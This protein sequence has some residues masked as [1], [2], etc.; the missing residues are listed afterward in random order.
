MLLNSKEHRQYAKALRRNAPNLPLKKRAQAHKYAGG[1]VGA[2]E[3][4]EKNP[5]KYA[6]KPP[7]PPKSPAPKASPSKDCISTTC[8]AGR[9]GSLQFSRLNS[10]SLPAGRRARSQPFARCSRQREADSGTAAQRRRRGPGHR[11]V[12][13]DRAGYQQAAEGRA[14]HLDLRSGLRLSY[15]AAIGANPATYRP[16][17]WRRHGA[18]FRGRCPVPPRLRREARRM[19]RTSA[20]A[21][22][23]FRRNISYQAFEHALHHAFEAGMAWVF[24]KCRRLTPSGA[25]LVIAVALLWLP[26]SFGIATALHATLIARAKSLPAWMQL[27]HAFATF[28]AKS[29]LLVLPV[30]PAAWPQAKEHPI[31]RGFSS[32]VVIARASIPADRTRRRRGG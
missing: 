28:I 21:V 11:A 13:S 18:A 8:P 25:L 32:F 22:E 3:A 23:R 6:P 17:D 2:G 27:L 12:G 20:P 15:S 4:Q 31:C 14:F 16:V 10:T 24:R 19:A 1:D 9:L 29:K 26:I 30:Y 5:E 7:S